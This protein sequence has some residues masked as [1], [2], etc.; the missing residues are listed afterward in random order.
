VPENVL[1]VSIFDHFP[2]KKLKIH[3]IRFI[4][5]FIYFTYCYSSFRK[6]D[7][8]RKRKCDLAS[9]VKSLKTIINSK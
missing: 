1:L 2:V 3:D 5:I 6:K 7:Q 4:R 9:I 8:Q